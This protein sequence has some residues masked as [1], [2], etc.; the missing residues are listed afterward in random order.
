MFEYIRQLGQEN[1]FCAVVLVVAVG[2]LAG[3][4]VILPPP[5]E[6]RRYRIGGR[7]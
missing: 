6:K 1:V 4:I 7:K 3:C 5:N 2:V